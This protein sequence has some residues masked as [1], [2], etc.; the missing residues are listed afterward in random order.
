MDRS[1]LT[2]GYRFASSL[3]R[4]ELRARYQFRG[5][6]I[7]LRSADA[8]FAYIQSDTLSDDEAEAAVPARP[9]SWP[10]GNPMWAIHP[11]SRI[12]LRMP[13]IPDPNRV[14]ASLADSPGEMP[15]A[16]SVAQL[17]ALWE[18]HFAATTT[19]SESEGNIVFL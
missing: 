15:D 12:Q 1:E 6:G 3:S 2:Q 7:N 16:P 19:P 8:E 11:S 4:E 13:P 10:N 14:F 18:N 9:E 5:N 17:R